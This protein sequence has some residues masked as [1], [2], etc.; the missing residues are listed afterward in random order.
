MNWEMLYNPFKRISPGAALIFGLP[1]LVV[2]ALLAWQVGAHMDGAL[3]I[4]LYPNAELR[5]TLVES[6]L[7]WLFVAL[8]FWAAGAALS[9]EGRNPLPYFAYT[10][11][12][13]II[14]IP[15]VAISSNSVLGPHLSQF[16]QPQ[17]GG[18]V[19]VQL[20]GLLSPAFLVL[21]LLAL[22]FVAW[23]IVLLVFAFKE[24]SG[25]SGGRAAA[26]IVVG[27]LVAEIASWIVIHLLLKAM[28]GLPTLL[29]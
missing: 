8:C 4:H 18:D 27:L 16:V 14:Y 23:Y 2:L 5:I 11:L 21:C 26:G 19:M 1:V 7:A 6:V 9:R 12:A 28:L 24:S 15:A 22:L 20:Q 3:D 29:G 13:R 17:P 25:L 10:A